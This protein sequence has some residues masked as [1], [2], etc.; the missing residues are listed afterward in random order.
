MVRLDEVVGTAY[1]GEQ[2]TLAASLLLRPTSYFR[3]LGD[4]S[5]NFKSV[6]VETFAMLL[7]RNVGVGRYFVE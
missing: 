1:H 5:P 2:G 7:S 3:P 4:G 6:G